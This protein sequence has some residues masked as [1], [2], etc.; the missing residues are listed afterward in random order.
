MISPTERE[1]NELVDEVADRLQGKGYCVIKHLPYEHGELD[2]Y[3]T[4]A[5]REVYVEVKAHDG[6]HQRYRAYSQLYR[7]LANRD[8]I[9]GLEK[10]VY[11]ARNRQGK[12]VV[13][14]PPVRMR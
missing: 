8:N 4:K 9:T 3:A 2:I 1:H 10:L 5:Q 11:V 14:R 7:W 12:L 6:I 13:E